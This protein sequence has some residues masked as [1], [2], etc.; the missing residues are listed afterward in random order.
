MIYLTALG[1]R[2][3]TSSLAVRGMQAATHL[4][5]VGLLMLYSGYCAQVLPSVIRG[6]YKVASYCK[7]P[8]HEIGGKDD[9]IHF[10]VDR[11]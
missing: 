2:L 11:M 5:V 7:V 6:Y 10:L 8:P 3:A 9:S 4:I 1:S